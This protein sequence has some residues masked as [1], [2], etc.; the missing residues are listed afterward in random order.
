MKKIIL[1]LFSLSILFSEVQTY[2]NLEIPTKEAIEQVKEKQNTLGWSA[3]FGFRG[4]WDVSIGGGSG[5]YLGSNIGVGLL[6]YSTEKSYHSFSFDFGWN[7][8][9]N[10]DKNNYCLYLFCEFEKGDGYGL[11]FDLNWD[12]AYIFFKSNTYRFET[13]VG[14]GIG[15]QYTNLSANVI[16][17]RTGQSV[18]SEASASTFLLNINLGIR[19]VLFENHAIDFKVKSNLVNITNSVTDYYGGIVF[20]IGYT[21]MKL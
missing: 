4:I 8:Y 17:T 5:T 16:N 21:F 9:K 18:Y 3:G 20:M 14:L 6:L 12:W 13:L 7:S 2:S 1:F 11:A 15:G 19:N 10:W